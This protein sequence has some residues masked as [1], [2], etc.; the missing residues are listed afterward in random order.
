M[1]ANAFLS[2]FLP[3]GLD[4][5]R[6]LIRLKGALL[7]ITLILYQIYTWE[8]EGLKAKTIKATQS[9]F[10]LHLVFAIVVGKKW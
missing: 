4:G 9:S 6:R 10:N 2:L 5:D 7:G 3:S 8:L 1:E